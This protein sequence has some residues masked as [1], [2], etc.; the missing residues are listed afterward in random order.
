MYAQNMAFLDQQIKRLTTTVE[1]RNIEIKNL[2]KSLSDE[3]KRAD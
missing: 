2:E 3:K 1:L